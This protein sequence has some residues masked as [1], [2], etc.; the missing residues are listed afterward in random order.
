MGK[1]DNYF[2]SLVSCIRFTKTMDASS[3]GGSIMLCLQHPVV[4]G[5][6]WHW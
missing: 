3:N 2:Y 5:N 1:T 6:Q 4:K